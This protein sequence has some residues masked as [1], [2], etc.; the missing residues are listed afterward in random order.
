[1]AYLIEDHRTPGTTVLRVYPG[2]RDAR[3]LRGSRFLQA[4]LNNDPVGEV[5]VD[6]TCLETPLRRTTA[7]RAASKAELTDIIAAFAEWCIG[8]RQAE[9]V[10]EAP[11]PDP[12]R[13]MP[14]PRPPTSTPIGERP[15]R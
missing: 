14:L 11:D 7:E 8:V 15:R 5:E 1:M 10:D 6:L 4:T 2:D 13:S 12:R 3:A 9:A